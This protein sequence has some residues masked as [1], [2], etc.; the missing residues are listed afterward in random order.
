M[1]DDDD[2]A[3]VDRLPLRMKVSRCC[4]SPLHLEGEIIRPP[5]TCIVLEGTSTAA[6]S[7]GWGFVLGGAAVATS[8]GAQS[9]VAGEEDGRGGEAAPATGVPATSGEAVSED[10]GEAVD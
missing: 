6:L 5:G 8:V 7:E 1:A 3:P 10:R 2:E 4:G 9:Q